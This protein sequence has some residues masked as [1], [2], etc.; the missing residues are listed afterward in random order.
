M[1]LTIVFLFVRAWTSPFTSESGFPSN[2]N[3][4]RLGPLLFAWSSIQSI[5][6]YIFNTF[7]PS[8]SLFIALCMVYCIRIF[9]A[10]FSHHICNYCLSGYYC[11]YS[12][13]SG[14]ATPVWPS[15]FSP[16][17]GCKLAPAVTG[18][19]SFLVVQ[20]QPSSLISLTTDFTLRPDEAENIF[21][22]ASALATFSTL[23]YSKVCYFSHSVIMG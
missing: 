3:S 22:I 10:Y 8:S 4:L 9:V 7:L 18:L 21:P 2:G 23:G 6:K 12:H 11:R 13:F 16:T 15:L 14:A 19:N 1:N 20:S 17:S 5:H